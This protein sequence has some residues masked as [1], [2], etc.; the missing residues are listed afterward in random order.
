[1]PEYSGIK[2]YIVRDFWK[3][4]SVTLEVNHEI[5]VNERATMIN[6]FWSNH[7]DRLSAEQ[8]DVVKSVVRYFGFTMMRIMLAEGGADFGINYKCPVTGG[9]PGRY[10]S[11][12]LHNEE[13]WGGDNHAN[14]YGWCGI[15]VIAADVDAPTF[16]DVELEAS[17]NG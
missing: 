9:H 13:G 11:E 14:P 5:L 4:Y 16:D 6:E 2:R 1:M 7:A 8:G 3:D 10:W 17:D 15:R 12:D